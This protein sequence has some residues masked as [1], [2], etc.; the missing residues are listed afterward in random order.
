MTV[1]RVMGI[2]TE[3]G[4]LQPGRPNANPMLLSS[5]VVA[6]HAAARQGGRAK[7]RWDYDDEDPLQDAR[8]FHLQRAAAHPSL[9][10]DDPQRP[11]PSGDVPGGAPADDPAADGPQEVARSLVEEYEDPGAANVILTNGARLYVDHAHPE[12]SS[13]E[14]TNPL[15]AVRW[16]RAGELVML[17][18]VRALASTPA[19]PDAVLYKNNVDG[20]GAT[21]GTHENFLVDRAVPFVDLAARLMPFLV[22]RQVFTGAGRVGLGQRGEEPG[23]QLSQRAD[24]IEAEV[25]LETTLRRPIVNT[26]D[27]PHADPDRWRRLH[28]IIGDANLLEVPTYLKLGTT[29]LVLWLIERVASGEAKDLGATLDRLSLAD[30]VRAV[31]TVSHD[32]TLTERLPLADGRR[33][34]AIEVQR[35]YLVAVRTAIGRG[36]ADVDPQTADVLARWGSLLERLATDPASCAREVEWLAK[37]RLLEGLRRRDHLEWDHP[38]LAAVDLQWSDVRPER[39]LYHRLVGAGAVERLVTD[40]DVAAAVTDPPEDTRAYFRGRT[41]ARF[42]A[43]VSAASWDSVVFD[44]PGAPTLQR[45]PMRDPL[46]GTKAHVAGLLDSSPDVGSLLAALGS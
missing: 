14:V 44:V 32:L 13:P 26:R 11:A 23:F 45:V 46:R 17:A 10:T 16:D 36:A 12:Y 27:E 8:G 35:E 28:V 15:D 3:Y 39:G 24:Y 38:R 6:V 29:S 4:V 31:H 41:I 22:T 21:Y 37:L 34:T 43:H 25:G 7:A 42:G 2:E 9:L 19:M 1:R 33:L 30:P 40:A 5:H 20:K 18:S